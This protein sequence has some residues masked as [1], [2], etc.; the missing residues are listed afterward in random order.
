MNTNDPFF[1][2]RQACIHACGTDSPKA[3]QEACDLG[4]GY[5]ALAQ[6]GLLPAVLPAHCLKCMDADKPREI[7]E[8]YD[9]K[10]PTKLADIIVTVEI[11]EVRIITVKY[12]RNIDIP[13]K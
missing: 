1:S 7:G 3:A 8:I 9:V 10:L 2:I 4:R 6:T 12:V 13:R 5:A 11:T